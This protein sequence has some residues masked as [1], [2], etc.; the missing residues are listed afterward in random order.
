MEEVGLKMVVNFWHKNWYCVY[1]ENLCFFRQLYFFPENGAAR[2][3]FCP[4]TGIRCL[5]SQSPIFRIGG[6]LPPNC[7]GNSSSSEERLR[8]PV[9]AIP[10][11]ATDLSSGIPTGFHAKNMDLELV[12][13]RDSV[14][15][16]QQV[17]EQA[18]AGLGSTNASTKNLFECC[19]LQEKNCEG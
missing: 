18:F 4:H 14:H 10:K 2:S 9:S 5:F 19:E 11:D 16:Q 7:T 1:E 17:C 6:A 13:K 8:S 3:A 12:R 15:Q